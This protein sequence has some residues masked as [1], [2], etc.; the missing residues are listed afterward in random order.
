LLLGGT[1]IPFIMESRI[2]CKK[3]RELRL[4]CGL[5]VSQVSDELNLSRKVISRME[6]DETYN[7]GVLTLLLVSDYFNVRLDDLII[8]E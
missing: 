2:N 1:I 3:I 5:L 7:P 6:I 8:K 4:S